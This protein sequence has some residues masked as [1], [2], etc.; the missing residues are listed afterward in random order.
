MC[1]NKNCQVVKCFFLQILMI[2]LVCGVV[3]ALVSMESPLTR[4][5]AMSDLQAIVV[6]Q[7]SGK[8]RSVACLFW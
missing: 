4:A 7:V 6:K 2:A 3:K 5:V 1:F 8:N